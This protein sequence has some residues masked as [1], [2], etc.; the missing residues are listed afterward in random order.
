MRLL[1]APAI[2]DYPLWG[3]CMKKTGKA[4]TLAGKSFDLNR[5]TSA[6]NYFKDQL[7]IEEALEIE[8][9]RTMQFA[10]QAINAIVAAVGD[11]HLLHAEFKDTVLNVS[12]VGRT[13]TLAPA[14]GA[15]FDTRLVKPR[16]KLCRQVL[17]FTHIS[18]QE[19]SSLLC[20]F[21]VYSDGL[22]T[23]GENSWNLNDGE[24]SMANYMTS[25]VAKS[26]FECDLYWPEYDNLPEYLT[27][28]P[29]IEDQAST[30]GL[31]RSCIG[32]ECAVPKPMV[33][34]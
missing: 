2:I 31:S 21:R 14:H 3:I 15:A 23:D 1:I 11:V 25:L 22:C 33:K 16:A 27:S 19:K 4:G 10:S 30:E 9:L 28:I 18:T 12:T 8:L 6:V 7:S 34:S 29:V 26:L 13:L 24:Q 5:V 17:V 20:A 32:F